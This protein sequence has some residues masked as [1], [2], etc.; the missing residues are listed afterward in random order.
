MLLKGDLRG[1]EIGFA[2][3]A[4]VGGE[5]GKGG[6]G[7]SACHWT[8]TSTYTDSKGNTRTRVHHH[9]N[10][11]GSDGHPGR[12]GASSNYRARDG[13]PG[14]CGLLRI[15]VVAPDGSQDEY[16]SPYDLELIDFDVAREYVILEPDSLVSIDN[17]VVQNTGGMPTPDNFT[18]RISIESDRWLIHDGVDLVLPRSLDPGETFTF[19][20]QGLRVRLGDHVVDSPRKRSFRLQ[21][22]VSPTATME[23]GIGRPFRQFE[24]S[25]LI[26][27]QFPVEL[28]AITSLNSIAP[29]E[30]TRVIWAV[31]NRSQET[32]G[33]QYLL[34]AAR[35]SIKL[36][37]G[38]VDPEQLLFFGIDERPFDLVRAPFVKP[39]QDLSP[40]ETQV[41]ETRI[42]VKDHS[43][44]VAYQGFVIGADLDL[45]R[46]KSSLAS[47]EY[48]CVDYRRT[49]IRVSERY[50]REE[51]SR[52]LLIAN[53]KTTL[54]D[55]DNWTQLAD[56]FGSSL[57]VWDVSYYGFLDLAR[58]VNK[59]KSL[60]EQW[61]GMTIIVPNNYYQTPTGT[62]VAFQQL[63]K[64][65]FIRAAAD[66]DIC[67][68]I[69][70]DSRTGG[71]DA[72]QKSLIP[73][74]DGKSPSQLKT[75][76]DFL[77]A[78]SRWNKYV[79]R[80]QAVVGGATSTADEFADV[81]LG[82]VH[83]FDINK[84]T[85]LFQ[86]KQQWLAEEANRLA[87]KLQRDDPLHR[88]V[89]VHR[90]DTGDT[91]TSWGFFRRRKVGTLEARR[92]LDSTKGSAVLFEVD[93]IDAIDRDFIESD[94][95]KHGM[96]LALKFEDKVDRFIRLVSERVFPRFRERYV[97]RPLTDEE[98]QKIGA[99]LVN[100]IL[101]DIYN[102]QKVAREAKTWGPT[103]VRALMPKLNYLAERSLNYGVTFEQMEENPA[104]L[105]LLY[106]LVAG[107]QFIANESKSIWDSWL[108]P[109][110]VFKRSRAVSAHLQNRCDRIV[111]SIFGKDPSW[112]DKMT[113]PDDDYNP[114]GQA[115]KK[116][117]KG[118]ERQIADRE[119]EKRL[120]ALQARKTPLDQF[121]V[122]K[123]YPGLSYD[124]DL[125]DKSVRVL[126]GEQYDQYVKAERQESRMRYETER[127][128][129]SKRADLLVP[130]QKADTIKTETQVATPSATTAS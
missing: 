100:A 107:I 63:A 43:D 89:I 29:G 125:L 94:A 21:Q 92:T 38:D 120:K 103:G 118:I 97:D 41:F 83:E 70:G 114:F 76:K 11:G 48:R 15:I 58:A 115:K 117:P 6:R 30:S 17:V 104:N 53:Q 18:I 47:D 60:L 130:L 3:E 126:S 20:N 91:D 24:N 119:I 72:L 44:V 27:L 61:R 23:S 106:D 50:H 88:W 123:Q 56:Y 10:P 59:D 93:S 73:V 7:G 14:N 36:L 22:P 46:P 86:P 96:F 127:S 34:R 111:T 71:A 108:V 112:W 68:Y 78:V 4:G 40:G 102:E 85:L 80:N 101:A 95:N 87:K 64:A 51:G 81:S 105:T 113:G 67:F 54:N 26:R 121:S 37:G 90:Y 5:G 31:T 45:Q 39:I 28:K 16:A 13:A 77:R 35:S 74:D 42:G 110:S 75:Q 55:I 128:V 116:K 129:R 99:S 109:T 33:Q 66:F 52:F 79:E 12:H 82:A 62:T 8:T 25:Q 98:V 124:P 65:Q 9:H 122:A 84:R 69:V 2:G 57:D 19:S 49:F 1:G 32:F